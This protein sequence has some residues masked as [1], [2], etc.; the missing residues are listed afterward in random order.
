[1]GLR[2]AASTLENGLGPLRPQDAYSESL[3]RGMITGDSVWDRALSQQSVTD[4]KV[5]MNGD[6]ADVYEDRL[7]SLATASEGQFTPILV[8]VGIRLG[9]DRVTP[10]YWEALKASLQLPQSVGIAG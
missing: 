7:L 1:M 6:G 8:L 9:I 3:F 2:L 5:Y 4:L 10:A